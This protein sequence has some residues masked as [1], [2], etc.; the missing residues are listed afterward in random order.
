[1]SYAAVDVT[2]QGGQPIFLYEFV[3]PG[4]TWRFTS[5]PVPVSHAAQTWTP[6]AI[7]HSDVTQSSELNKDAVTLT[8]PRTNTFA[9]Q[10]L[11]EMQDAVTQVTIWRGHPD[12]GEFVAYWK[13]R[14]AAGSASGQA[15]RVECESIFT[16]L[17]RPGLRARY[18][19]TCRHSLYGRGCRLTLATF[20][21]AST[22]STISA[23]GM[24]MT[25]PAASSQADGWWFG[26]ILKFGDI[27]RMIIAHSGTSIT[28]SRPIPGLIATSAVS[29]HPGCDRSRGTCLTKFNNLDNYGGFPWIPLKN[30]MGGSSIV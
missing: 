26:G 5:S 25:I 10:F 3:Q 27:M 22:V 11:T 20:A 8:F 28:I 2:V 4:E 29:I 7:I 17:R 15:I 14:V 16:S 24:T 23:D 1:M 19:R 6:E 13:G 12:D 18:Q 21:T 9:Q 30:P